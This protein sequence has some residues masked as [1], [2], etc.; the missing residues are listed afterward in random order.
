MGKRYYVYRYVRTK[1]KNIERKLAWSPSTSK[2]GITADV[3]KVPEMKYKE[4]FDEG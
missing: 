3:T 2:K 4:D 1:V